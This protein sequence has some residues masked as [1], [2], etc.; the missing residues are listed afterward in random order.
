MS[1]FSIDFLKVLQE[2]S[3]LAGLSGEDASKYEGLARLTA[4]EWLRKLKPE[5]IL[6]E[7]EVRIT[8]LIATI[9]Y[10]R[11]VLLESMQ[12]TESFRVGDVS[13]TPQS[14][15]SAKQTLQMK[16]EVIL[17]CKDLFLDGGPFYFGAV[18]PIE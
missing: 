16:N 17:S 11:Y 4:E 18:I 13:V 10:C 6:P 12:N 2:F 14:N 15:L 9:V 7:N 5:S 8:T 1:D 3:T